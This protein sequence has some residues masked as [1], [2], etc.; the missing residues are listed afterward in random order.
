MKNRLLKIAISLIAVMSACVVSAGLLF[1]CN[2][3][4]D[5]TGDSS[6]SDK[7]IV[8]IST[9][10][11]TVAEFETIKLSATVENGTDAVR[12]STSD[13]SVATV[14][15]NG[16][17]RG[18]KSGRCNIVAVAGKAMA[19]CALTVTES[20]YAPVIKTADK[21]TVEIGKSYVG[22]ISVTFKGEDVTE[23]TKIE[24][25]IAS[26]C[27]RICDVVKG[28]GTVTFIAKSLGDADYYVSATYN[29]VFVN[30][31][32]SV[33]V[34][35]PIATVV[36]DGDV[37]VGDDGYEVKLFTVAEA[38]QTEMPLSFTA[39]EGNDVIKNAVINWDLDSEW[40]DPNIAEIT[41]SNGSYTVKKVSAG[42]TDIIG[43]YRSP[44]GKN[45][46]VAIKV[47]VEKAVKTL[48]IRPEIEVEDLSPL[49]LPDSFN[50]NILSLTLDGVN[51]YSSV[52]GKNVS[53]NK[54]KLPVSASKLG[55]REMILSTA[56]VDYKFT[57]DI[58]T[59]KISNK[60]EFDKMRDLA[61]SNGDVTNTGVLDGYFVLDGNVEYNAEFVSITDSGEIWSINNKLGGAGWNDPSRYGFKGVFDGRGY[62]VNG[63]TVR[64]RSSDRESGGIFGF[65]NND[66]IIKN[67]SFTDA[68]LY[69]NNGFICSY[70]GGLI[71]NVGITFAKIGMGNE[72]RDLFSANGDPRTMGA[73]FSCGGSESA[74]VRNCFVDA[75]GADIAYVTNKDR[76]DLANVILGT[77]TKNVENLVVACDHARA[78]KILTESGASYTAASYGDFSSSVS[79][80]GV[81]SEFDEDIWTVINGIPFVKHAADTIDVNRDVEFVQI[82][83]MIVLGGSSAIKVNT[84]YARI[85]AEGLYGGI[86]F[87]NGIIYVPQDAGA[88]NITLNAVSYLNGS[89]VTAEI[90]IADSRSVT[91]EH[92]RQIVET[93]ANEID[94]SF[95]GEYVGENATVTY[96]G[97]IL[98]SGVVNNGKLIADLTKAG[99]T[100][101]LT[102]EIVSKKNDVYYTFGYNVLLVTKIIRTADDMA[103]VRITTDQLNAYTPIEGYYVLGNDI[104]FANAQLSTD[105]GTV[106]N[107]L[108]DKYWNQNQ[109]FRGTFDGLNHKIT[110][111]KVGQGGIFG[112]VGQGAVIKNV[113]FENISYAGAYGGSLFGYSVINATVQNVNI[114]VSSYTDCSAD[115]KSQGLLGARYTS[116]CNF[117]N[118]TIDAGTCDVYSLFGREI[119]VNSYSNVEIKVKSYTMFGYEGAG[120][121][122]A[123]KTVPPTNLKVTIVA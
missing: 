76:S 49:V 83:E 97:V 25:S 116:G 45:V 37:S 63:L 73:F 43:N 114:K 64:S 69:E 121:N 81:I 72:N 16:L 84:R 9:E 110:N 101:E 115:Q 56:D 58:Y 70:G 8:T 105:Y 24:W 1:G 66:A 18:L 38:G 53:L 48:D 107:N 93:T 88:G 68:G 85:T 77:R 26:G 95:A 19:S 12:W 61:R 94:L 47:I 120:V 35:E 67:V 96:G 62:N 112:F 11:A 30:K 86:T 10:N 29:G 65:T 122:T 23:K 46:R 82:A 117:M 104:D 119:K 57:A 106:L 123:D 27:D 41:G 44:N 74:K 103:A 31:S 32:I 34:I 14:D 91:V 2:K 100:G 92:E 5:N 111:V 28:N 6:G 87:E 51:V 3:T 17:V 102:L 78:E 89:H 98:G 55:S 4:S 80:S 59:L 99:K 79:L 22:K 36:P 39:Y 20:V 52:S 50:E 54:A 42:T 71:E 113:D 21:I 108:T 118:V 33:K 15:E 40:Y 109:G 13:G 60:A 7:T 75:S 90:E